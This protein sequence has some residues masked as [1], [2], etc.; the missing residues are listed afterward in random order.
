MPLYQIVTIIAAAGS[1]L[2]VIIG[3]VALIF[4]QGRFFG[5]LMEHDMNQD[6]RIEKNCNALK[7]LSV[8]FY[9]FKTEFE[10]ARYV[11]HDQHF[12]ICEQRARETDRDIDEIKVLISAGEKRREDSRREDSDYREKVF[13]LLSE[14]KTS[15]DVFAANL[16]HLVERVKKLE[17]R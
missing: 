11:T 15:V 17:D 4:R 6:Q 1:L 13:R 5:K 3:V 12:V 16:A 10:R 14:I 8:N 7:A 9:N 2:T